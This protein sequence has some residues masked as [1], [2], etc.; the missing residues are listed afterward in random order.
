MSS[1]NTGQDTD[2]GHHEQNRLTRK[3]NRFS[4]L[5]GSSN[6]SS[7]SSPKNDHTFFENA[8]H[9]DGLKT[10]A[11]TLQKSNRIS[12]FGSMRSLRSLDDEEKPIRSESKS[13]SVNDGEEGPT[14]SRGLFGNVVLHHGEVQTVGNMFKKRT[15]YLV[16]TE[17]H[18]IRFKNQQRAAEMFSTI[19]A[20]LGRSNTYRQ[21]MT[22]VGSY[23]EMQFGNLSRYNFW[24]CP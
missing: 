4:N 2:S 13:S 21:S 16:L 10:R 14:F 9:T 12:V 3:H 18:L 22:S 1:L 24:D 6:P 20:S 19:P 17:T 8:E 23:K 7:P 11:R 5:S 15:Q